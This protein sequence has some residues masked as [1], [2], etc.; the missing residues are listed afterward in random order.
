M[1]KLVPILRSRTTASVSGNLIVLAVIADA[2]EVRAPKQA[3]HDK[4]RSRRLLGR[5]L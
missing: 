2:A 5:D 4:Q 3:N 1:N